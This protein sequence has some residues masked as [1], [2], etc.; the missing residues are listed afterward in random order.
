MWDRH[1]GQQINGEWFPITLIVEPS[2]RR[3][4]CHISADPVAFLLVVWNRQSQW[5]A[6][7]K[8]K[9]M[10]WGRKPWLGPQFRPLM[11]NP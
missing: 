3:V 6:I 9:L 2:S 5:T 8:G 4:D 11:R 10:A 1:A 7:A